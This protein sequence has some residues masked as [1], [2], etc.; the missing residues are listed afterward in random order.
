MTDRN[1]AIEALDRIANTAIMKRLPFC[2]HI[3]T[4]RQFMNEV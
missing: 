4:L 2:E 1:V 3:A